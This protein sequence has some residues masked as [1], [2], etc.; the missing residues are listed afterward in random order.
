VAATVQNHGPQPVSLDA[1]LYVNGRTSDVQSI[2]LP[3][4][5][6][7][8][9]GEANPDRAS[10]QV[11]VFDPLEFEGSGLVEVE[12]KVSDA[13]AADDRAW[14]VVEPPRRLSVLL[15]AD[16]N[17]ILEHVLSILP[18]DLTIMGPEEYEQAPEAVVMQGKRSSFD[19][20]LLDR[21][22]TSR[23]PSGN[24]FFWGGV[25]QI[26]GLSTGRRIADEV[27]FDWDDTHPVLRH[28][29]VET[30]QANEWVELKL[31]REA[32][33]VIDG[34]TSPV[35]A[36]LTRDASQYLISAF[37]L[38]AAGPEGEPVFNT[39]WYANLDFVVFTHNALYYLGAGLSSA[40]RGGI[41][42]G[43]PV[44][45]PAPGDLSRVRIRRPDG[46]VDELPVTASP[47]LHYARTR[48]VGAYRLEAAGQTSDAFVVNLFNP[49]ESHVRPAYKLAIGASEIR[50]QG[51]EVPANVPAWPALLMAIFLLLLLEWAVYNRRVFV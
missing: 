29:T 37:S 39:H 32:V 24:Y 49:M 26:D 12:L 43:E 3:S 15:V 34:Q 18:L 47:V 44:S 19:V 5:P 8:G 4:F 30:L 7:S 46:A 45:I 10:S 23:L 33:S 14:A 25:P 41:A 28:V 42:P 21:H 31:P 2:Q 38:F 9:E 48:Q 40:G 51:G 17:P 27:I 13:L 1:V 35:L 20:V 36:Y 6:E 16:D 11:I 22:S 50:G